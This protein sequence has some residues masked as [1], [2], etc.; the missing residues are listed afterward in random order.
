MIYT[1]TTNPA[2]DYILRFDKFEDGATIRARDY[3]EQNHP[4]SW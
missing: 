2:I 4:Q 1:I 3:G